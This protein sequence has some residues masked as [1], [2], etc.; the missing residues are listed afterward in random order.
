[1]A[2]SAALATFLTMA[3]LSLARYGWG[4]SEYFHG[5]HYFLSRTKTFLLLDEHTGLHDTCTTSSRIFHQ[6]GH[7]AYLIP[8]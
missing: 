4:A 3:Q 7:T 6:F 1:M 2:V 5:R 8:G